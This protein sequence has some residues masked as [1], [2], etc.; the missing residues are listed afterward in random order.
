MMSVIAR[1][2]QVEGVGNRMVVYN[3]GDTL[4]FFDGDPELRCKTGAVDWYYED[5]TLCQS[6]SEYTYPESGRGVHAVGEGVNE[7][8]YVFDYRDYRPQLE[9]LDV[10]AG[11][12]SLTGTTIHLVGSVP[13]ITYPLPT[14]GTRTYPRTCT[15]RHNDVYWSGTEWSSDRTITYYRPLAVGQYTLPAFYAT[16]DFVL[17][18]DTIALGLYGERDSIVSDMVSPVAVKM[19]PSSQ[20]T[21]R[22]EDPHN[23]VNPPTEDTSLSGSA[24]LEV[25]FSTHPTE[26]AEYYLW[27]VYKGQQLLTSRTDAELH[28][29]FE[30]NDNYLVVGRAYS[31]LCECRD[32]QAEGCQ[33]DSITFDVSIDDS[34]LKV[35]N[36]FTP[37]GDGVNDEFRVMYASLREYHIWIYDR[38]GHKVYESTDPS[39][40][41]DGTIGN[42]KAAEGAYFYVIRA[43]G[44]NAAKD[45]SYGTKLSHKKA[46][47]D[48]PESKVGVYRLSGDIN[49]IRGGK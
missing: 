1:A 19:H 22:G 14:A 43:L 3:L 36:V 34:M 4:I 21:K 10:E 8:V 44:T 33:Q 27:K 30:D 42:M 9:M 35:P 29:T 48:K 37:N 18:A 15:I 20:T 32:P 7:W 46:L 41:W 23:E 2:G 24:P 39:K 26:A 25:L 49:L 28:Y 6:Q 47:K 12:D 5:G 31:T 13:A 38:W 16:T 45:A 11:C 40:G 17:A